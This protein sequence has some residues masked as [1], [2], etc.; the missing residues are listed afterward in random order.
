MS[1]NVSVAVY[2]VLLKLIGDAPFVI[3]AALYVMQHKSPGASALFI[4]AVLARTFILVLNSRRL[5]EVREA[6][7]AAKRNYEDAVRHREEA[8]G[9]HRKALEAY[10]VAKAVWEAEKAR[11][12]FGLN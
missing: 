9:E 1:S 12:G 10:E 7:L 6:Y 5:R 4:V 3:M 2:L 8:E 11:R